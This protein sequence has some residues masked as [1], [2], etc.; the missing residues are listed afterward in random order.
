[1]VKH[2]YGKL[3]LLPGTQ[4][5][6]M[7][8]NELNLYVDYLKKDIETHLNDLSDKKA[9]YF[10]KF[11]DQLLEGIE[12]YKGLIP[13]INNQADA[14]MEKMYI[15]LAEAEQRLKLIYNENLADLKQG[16]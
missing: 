14:Y 2:I 3:N 8:I 6:N 10:A 16:V 7:F 9:K 13:V 4:R 5:S 15:Q 11:K 12:Y 1:M